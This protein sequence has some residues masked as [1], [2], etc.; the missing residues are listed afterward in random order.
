MVNSLR[1]NTTEVFEDQPRAN[2]KMSDKYPIISITGATGSGTTVVQQAFKEIFFR[3]KI[4]ACFLQGD[5]FLHYNDTDAKAH[6]K[7]S[8]DEGQVIS[9]YGPDLN[10]YYKLENSFKQYSE[11]GRCELRYKINQ[12]NKHLYSD[13]NQGFTSWDQSAENT[14]CLFYE[15]LHGG[16]VAKQWTR[17]Q[18]E[19]DEYSLK[20]RR[21]NR[22][23]RVDVAQYVD[24]LVGVVPAINLEWMQRIQ[25][26]VNIKTLTPDQVTDNILEQLQDYIH[27]IIP[28]FSMTDI[29]FQRMPVVDTSNPF[30]M[31]NI[32]TE[33]ELLLS[34][35]KNPQNIIY[36][37]T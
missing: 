23:T 29:N 3:Q 9:S 22:N 28:Q 19:D 1:V 15:G 7:K 2:I 12:E 27:F 32:P 20:D 31:Q 18:S 34:V 8:L 33:K 4:N 11:T 37:I 6:I 16:V 24:L 21:S 25:H 30:E 26:D 14:D 13:D 10:N 35:L 17:R 5:G 36:T